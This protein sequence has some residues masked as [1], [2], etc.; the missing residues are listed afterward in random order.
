MNNTVVH[1]RLRMGIEKVDAMTSSFLGGLCLKFLA[2]CSK[3]VVL[4]DVSAE[5]VDTYQISV[6]EAGHDK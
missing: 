3:A 6:V 1:S 4:V 2:L 5:E